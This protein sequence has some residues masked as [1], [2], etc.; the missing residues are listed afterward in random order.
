MRVN[1]AS[2]TATHP[3]DLARELEKAGVLGKYY[4]ALPPF[5]VSGLPP[6]RIHS[7]PYLLLPHF[8]LRRA[9]LHA[10]DKRLT[11]AT[12]EAFDFWLSRVQGPADVLHVL[13]GFGLRAMRHAK[14]RRVVTVCDRGSSHIRFQNDLLRDEF[15]RWNVPYPEINPAIIA[16]EEAE[17]R[18]ADTVVVP[19][20][21]ARQSFLRMGVD[22]D[23]VATVPYGVRLEEYFPVPKRDDVFRVLCVASLTIRKGLGYLLEAV[24]QLSVPRMEVVLRG[25][26]MPETRGL[27][28]R[29]E[30]HFRLDPPRPRKIRATSVSEERAEMRDLYSQASVLVLPSVEEGLALVMGQAMACGVPVIATTNTGAEDLIT[31]GRDG[32]IVPVRDPA[33][34]RDRLDYLASHPEQRA[35]MGRAALE[36][37]R[38]R[39]GWDDYA[40]TMRRLY[41][42]RLAGRREHPIA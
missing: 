14:A 26:P 27:L 30:G 16:K 2:L 40:T 11:W 10:L 21:F 18:E 38:S 42:D 9:G 4:S 8:L 36:K 6:S 15:S 3:L 22:G 17:Y 5:R 1:V 28:A 7:N 24:S 37:V 31:D 13:S 32:F 41:Q 20:T 34:I 25:T 12:T 33:A 29:Y 39:H 35:A 23:K 19:S